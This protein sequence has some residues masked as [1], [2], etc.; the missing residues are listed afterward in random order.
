MMMQPLFTFPDERRLP[1][2]PK[3]RFRATSPHQGLI[4][5]DNVPW[6][7]SEG[8]TAEER[9]IA[10]L[11]CALEDLRYLVDE[12]PDDY[13]QCGCCGYDHEYEPAEAQEWHRQHACECHLT[14]ECKK[15]HA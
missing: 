6:W 4:E 9:I 1:K 11:T 5:F 13:E 8:L 3:F 10:N 2:A 7:R 15:S 14:N 12:L